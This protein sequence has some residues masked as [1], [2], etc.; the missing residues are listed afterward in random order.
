[1]KLYYKPG[2]CS[3]ASHIALNEIGATFDI[4]SVDTKAGK[5]ESGADFSQ[6]NPKG[7]VPVLEVEGGEHL[8]EGAAVLQFIADKAPDSGLVPAAG[9]IERTRVQSS[10]NYVGS[11]LHKAFSPFFS[12]NPPEGAKRDEAIAR[13]S[14][15]FKHVEATLSD[16]RPFLHGDKF[17]VA[18]AYAFVVSQWALF[19]GI[20]LDSWPNVAKFVERIRERPAVVKAMT[21]EGL[22]G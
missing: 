4:E 14:D 1:M 17:T 16:G 13:L 7:Y 6:I 20:G 2:A 15:K 12:D 9:T 22:I 18:D 21:A 8:S 11:E 5:T 3:L 19:T 10:L